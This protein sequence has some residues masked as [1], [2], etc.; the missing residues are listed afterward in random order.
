MEEGALD[1]LDVE[2]ALEIQ[3]VRGRGVMTALLF[4][5]TATL[6]PAAKKRRTAESEK[7]PRAIL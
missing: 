1:A 2:G 6:V 7:T 3:S 4:L 5:T